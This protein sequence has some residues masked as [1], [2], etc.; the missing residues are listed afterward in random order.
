MSSQVTNAL[1]KPSFI[2][3]NASEWTTTKLTDYS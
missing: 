2:E 1:L 3:K